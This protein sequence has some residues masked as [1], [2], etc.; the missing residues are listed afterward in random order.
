[1]D[2]P[3][4]L[5]N[6]FCNGSVVF[7]PLLL[8]STA[9]HLCFQRDT[10]HLFPIHELFSCPTG[11]PCIYFC[12]MF[13]RNTMLMSH[14]LLTSSLVISAQMLCLRRREAKAR[15]LGK[16]T[17]T[18]LY[19]SND[20]NRTHQLITLIGSDSKATPIEL[21]LG[22]VSKKGHPN[23]ILF[24]DRLKMP[25]KLNSFFRECVK[26]ANPTELFNREQIKCH[27]APADPLHCVFLPFQ[28]H[29]AI[30][31]SFGWKSR[32]DQ[33]SRL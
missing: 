33:H 2:C 1:M 24:R 11:I 30:L 20:P 12:F 31:L 5:C 28:S 16:A 19:L 21:F 15:P 4:A 26:E 8:L 29:A 10:F 22:N 3:K 17:T 27:N 14:L 13:C 7:I 9:S 18:E 23:W 25:T 6:G 32:G